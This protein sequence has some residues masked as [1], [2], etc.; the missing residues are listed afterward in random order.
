MPIVGGGTGT[1]MTWP[2]GNPY[3]G[4]Q[5]TEPAEEPVTLDKVKEYL[6]IDSDAQDSLLTG[7]IQAARILAE[8]WSRR[9]FIARTLDLWLESWPASNKIVLPR[10]PLQS[11]VWVQFIDTNNA[12]SDMDADDYV[13][14]TFHEPG[15]IILGYGKSW[16]SATLRPGPAINV[17][18]VAGYGT[19]SQVPAIYKQAILL[20]TGHFY[21]NREEVTPGNVRLQQ[22]PL[23]ARLLLTVDRGDF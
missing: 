7:Y 4:G 18:Y 17:R 9:A 23:G 15:C 19:P 6:R 16:P 8:M 10:P 5:V 3:P 22:V 12:T 2:L 1:P 11:V 14:D 21:E 13:L 20:M